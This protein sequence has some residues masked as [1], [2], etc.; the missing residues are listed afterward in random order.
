MCPAGG[1]GA[2]AAAGTLTCRPG[3]WRG[4]LLA[5]RYGVY[6]L[7]FRC[8]GLPTCKWGCGSTSPVFLSLW[9]PLLLPHTSPLSLSRLADGLIKTPRDRDRPRSRGSPAPLPH[10]RLQARVP[11]G[12]CSSGASRAPAESSGAHCQGCFRQS[13]H[14]APGLGVRAQDSGNFQAHVKVP[15][16]L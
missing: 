12:P 13:R 5:E 4:P 8:L 6:A 15:G 3:P 7:A 9:P 11:Q 1:T 14:Q 16:L 10:S 2:E